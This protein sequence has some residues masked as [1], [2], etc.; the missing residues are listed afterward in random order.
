MSLQAMPT[1]FVGHMTSSRRV[2][3]C[4]SVVA[5]VKDAT[6]ADPTL[7]RSSGR[8]AARLC[9]GPK[10]GGPRAIETCEE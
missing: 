7:C 6:Q 4:N 2:P 5:E 9:R 10:P 8:A 3:A 1:R